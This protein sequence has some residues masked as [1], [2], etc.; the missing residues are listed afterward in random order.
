MRTSRSANGRP[1][2]RTI[3]TGRAPR[4]TSTRAPAGSGEGAPPVAVEHG[5]RPGRVDLDRDLAVRRDHHRPGEQRVRVARHQQQRLHLRPHQRPARGER[6][7]RG[8][9]RGR[10][11]HAVAAERRHRPSVDLQHHLEDPLA[12]ALLDGGLVERPGPGQHVAVARARPRRCVIRS[13]IAYWPSTMA[14]RAP[15]RT[16]AR[17]RRG[18]RSGPR[19]TP[20][21]GTPTGRAISAARSS[22]PSPPS[23][24]TTSAPSAQPGRPSTIRGASASGRPSSLD[25]GPLLADARAAGCRPWPAGRDD[26]RPCA[27]WSPGPRA[28]RRSTSRV[29]SGPSATASRRARRRRRR[30]PVAAAGG[31]RT[32]R[33]RTGPATGSPPRRAAPQAQRPRRRATSVSA[34]SRSPG[35]RTTPP[36]PEPLAAHLELRLHHRQQLPVGLGARRERRQHGAQRDERQVGHGQVDRA[37]RSRRVSSARTLVRS[38]TCD[39]LVAAQPPDQLPVPDVDGDHLGRAAVQ[40]HVGEPAGGGARVEAAQARG[41]DRRTRPARRSACARRGTPTR[42]RPLARTVTGVSRSTTVAGLPA[43]SR[44]PRPG[45][46]RSAPRPARRDGRARGAPVRRPAGPG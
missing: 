6:V 39:P 27:G 17:P 43:A 18:T 45:P 40:Q 31:G 9:G 25:L 37:R 41:I 19:L 8:A 34:P 15:V 28:G 33:C 44:G 32:R 29:M 24:S 1:S 36:A 23:T 20:S 38:C 16:P 30:V 3:R 14:S 22:V 46:A 26:R 5:G 35:S 13:S 11:Q 10:A 4:V 42:A 21:S 12:G 2:S 7:G